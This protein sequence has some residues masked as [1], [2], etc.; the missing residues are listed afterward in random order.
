MKA[1]DI[2]IF[3][4]TKKTNLFDRVIVATGTSNRQTRALAKSVHDRVRAE[5]G[6]VLSM[7]GDDTG[8]WVLVDCGIAVAHIFLPAIRDYYRLEE[9]WGGVEV[10]IAEAV[11]TYRNPQAAVTAAE[12]SADIKPKKRAAR[13]RVVLEDEPEAPAAKAPKPAPKKV[14]VKRPTTRDPDTLPSAKTAAKSAAKPAAKKPAAKK[15]ARPTKKAAG[16]AAD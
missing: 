1:L 13:K 2:Q 7:E 10:S 9:I 12:S 14:A 8:E 5:D 4:V 11:D 3:D 16:Q 6:A 15:A